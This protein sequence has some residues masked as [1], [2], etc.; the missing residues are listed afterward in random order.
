MID[1]SLLSRLPPPDLIRLAS[2]HPSEAAA[3]FRVAARFCLDGARCV[4]FRDQEQER[5]A[6]RLIADAIAL[7]TLAFQRFDS[8]PPR[9]I[10]IPATRRAANDANEGPTPWDTHFARELADGAREAERWLNGHGTSPL[11]T[12]LA[13]RRRLYLKEQGREAFEAGFLRR[14]QGYLK[15]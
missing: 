3:H 11:W 8:P 2:L 5:L 1:R 9:P 14:I 6:H 7:Y 15:A 12:E 10:T 4:A 13:R